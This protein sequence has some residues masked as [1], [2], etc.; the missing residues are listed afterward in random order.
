MTSLTIMYKTYKNDLPW[1]KYSLLSLLKFY[2]GEYDLVIYCHDQAVEELSKLLSELK[3]NPKVIPVHYDINGYLKQMVVKC[4]C[5]KDIKTEYVSI[6][7][8][9]VIFKGPVS[10]DDF[11]IDQ[12]LKW[13]FLKKNDTNQNE[14]VWGVW[15]D[16]VLRMTRKPM[17]IYY[18]Y[19][20]FPFVFKTKTLEK[21]DLEFAKL[22]NCS[23]NEF[24]EKGLREIGVSKT[25]PISGPNGNFP[26][27][28]EEFEYLGWFC[29][30][31]TDDYVFIEGPNPSSMATRA[32]YWS[33]GGIASVEHEILEILK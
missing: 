24:C 10:F 14:S 23:Y 12:R 29:Q 26:K 13:Y 3:L 28:F 16:S 9:D 6:M 11:L 22:H 33:H 19:N 32:Q 17:T 31:H 25:D 20:A 1:L 21:A 15:G 30:N 7:D 4:S 18:M 27:I 2:K 5:W 8:S